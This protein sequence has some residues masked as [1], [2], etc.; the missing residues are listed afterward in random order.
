MKQE[1][2]KVRSKTDHGK[3]IKGN[4]YHLDWISQ[5]GSC[6]VNTPDGTYIGNYSIDIFED[7]SGSDVKTRNFKG[8]ENDV[9]FCD[10][11]VG[12]VVVCNTNKGYKYLIEGGK[13]R[14]KELIPRQPYSE[15]SGQIRLEGYK[16]RL[17][18]SS[19]NFRRLNKQ[20]MRKLTIEQIFDKEENFSVDFIRKFEKTKNKDKIIMT[21]IAE[22]I[23]DKK[24]HGMGLMDWTIKKS[25][26][27]LQ[28]EKSD[29]DKIKEMKLKEIF[30]IFDNEIK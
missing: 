16:R 3:L 20:E 11:K 14:I 6:R 27:Y 30:N 8:F 23:V 24:R 18:W 26:K 25:G 22:S 19:Y 12:D 4:I 9:K 7:M 13:Y 15:Y 21:A 5:Y 1:F 2:I 29:F 28:L 17:H 10:L